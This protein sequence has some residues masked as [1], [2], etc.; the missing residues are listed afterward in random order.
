MKTKLLFILLLAFSLNILYS[1]TTPISDPIFEQAL[2]DLTI[3]TNG[4]NGNILN[5]DA[6][7]VTSLDV[8]GLGITN[9]SGIEAFT[10][11]QTLSCDNNNIVMLD[12][13]SNTNLTHVYCYYN[14]LTSLLLPNSNT[15]EQLEFYN[16]FL[17][18]IDLTPYS[19]L[20][21]LRS[22]NNPTLGSLDVSD[23]PNLQ[24]LY[25]QNNGLNSLD[26]SQNPNLEILDCYNNNLMTLDVSNNLALWRL[27]C[28]DN[29][30][31]V[32]DVEQNVLLQTLYCYLNDMTSLSLPTTVTLTNLRCQA[33]DLPSLDASGLTG[34]QNLRCFNN[35][36]MTTLLLPPTNSLTYVDCDTTDISTLDASSLMNLNYLDVYYC[37]SLTNLML[38]PTTALE[39]LWAYSTGLS[40]LD[41]TSN[42][43]LLTLDI[44]N[45][46]FT[47]IDVS[48]LDNL[49]YFWCNQSDNLTSLNLK[50]GNNH[51]MPTMNSQQSPLL[52]CIE[53]D[54]PALAETYGGWT[55][56]NWTD[57]MVTCPPLSTDKFNLSSISI[58]PNPTKDVFEIN[59]MIDADYKLI[60]LQGQQILEGT[61][62]QGLNTLDVSTVSNGIYLL[63]FKNDLGS[64]SK[65][66]VKN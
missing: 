30:I 43:G 45:G 48:M 20:T 34:L 33:N 41:F 55:I 18:S 26:V 4:L 37:Y 54:N 66:L 50:N 9:L 21:F 56:D 38:P 61:F 6:S 40:D 39:T 29:N 23:S 62:K 13:R 10:S 63:N 31:D 17:T 24:Y 36:N 58:Y 28:Q 46:N 25:C 49:L 12:L 8:G 52:A 35:P 27:W 53:V 14:S 60:S 32:L 15:L 19:N 51:N 59:M 22:Y 5:S 42:T 44:A 11:L 65:K 7:I 2:I 57:Y 16:N 1:Q 3:D 47:S 64:F